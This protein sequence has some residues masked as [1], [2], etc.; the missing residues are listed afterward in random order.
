MRYWPAIVSILRPSALRRFGLRRPAIGMLLALGSVLACRPSDAAPIKQQREWYEQAKN[1]LDQ[2]DLASFRRLRGKLKAYPLA[3]YLDYRHFINDL[4]S[5]SPRDFNEFATQ[6]RKLPFIGTVRSRYLLHLAQRGRWKGILQIQK[7]PPRDE[8]LRC[9]YFRAHLATG[10]RSKAFEGA[11]KLWRNGQSIADQC[12]PLFEAW[13]AA[14]K[15]T[16]EHVLDRMLLA[17]DRRNGRLLRYL[18]KELTSRARDIGRQIVELYQRPNVVDSFSSRVT[19]SD[20]H[21]AIASVAIRRWSRRMPEATAK[22]FDRVARRLKF[23]D[24]DKGA[25][26]SYV[27][28]R[29]MATTDS[30]AARWRDRAI[31]EGGKVSVIESR[32]RL[33]LRRAQWRSAQSW[34]RRLPPATRDNTR[35]TFWRGRLAEL[36]GNK[37]DGRALLT[38]ILGRADFYSAA[39]A[40][41]LKRPIAY[42]TADTPN[43]PPSVEHHGDTLARVKELI[44]LEK[45]V[46][47]KREWRSLLER[48]DGSEE[49][50]GLA[51][52]AA[53][54][55][56]YH[57]TV[58]ATISG[59]LWNHMALRF[60]FAY[61]WWFE[62]FSKERKL[63]VSTMLATARLE[64]ALDPLAE[65][66]AR[67]RGLLQMLPS[68]AREEARRIKFK[69][70]G[71]HTLF[72]PG[73]N[74]RLGSSYLKRMLGR[75]DGNRI[76]ALASYNAGYAR[77]KQWKR[78]TNGKLDAYAFIEQIPYHE[79]RG[80]VLSGLMFDIYYAHLLGQKP[81][82]LSPVEATTR[83]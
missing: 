46:D 39:A 1:A 59:E 20:R 57:L 75:W 61:R 50:L 35:W 37:S 10:Q 70:E 71:K 80:Y 26:A 11:S 13:T 52:H 22:V 14:G 18:E 81:P 45:I 21:R 60:P 27:A 79:T 29:L 58:Q 51:V 25:L 47:A 43:K 12:D 2:D 69:Y 38:S 83:Y 55:K 62:F 16:D 5:R 6:Y 42:P 78:E 63:P 40:T 54:S 7:K 73:V 72:E 67:A 48:A 56:W 3:P 36:T 82:L 19:P 30:E 65:S 23:S 53:R 41:L 31:R 68:T 28:I 49:K 66:P 9:V 4:E 15:R 17:F 44:A 64:S 74:I 32:I 33:A 77:T 34:I 8:A 24:P 76:L